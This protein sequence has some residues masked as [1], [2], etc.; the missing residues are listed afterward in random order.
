M[1][2]GQSMADK[3]ASKQARNQITEKILPVCVSLVLVHVYIYFLYK[4]Y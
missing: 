2:V 1:A 3:K 4:I